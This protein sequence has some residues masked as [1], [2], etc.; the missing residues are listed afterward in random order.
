MSNREKSREIGKTPT[1]IAQFLHL[2]KKGKKFPFVIEK[3]S[4]VY[5]FD[6][7]I[8]LKCSEEFESINSKINSLLLLLKENSKALLFCKENYKKFGY[9]NPF[10]FMS[11]LNKIPN[12]PDTKRIGLLG[13]RREILKAMEEFVKR[14]K[15][16]WKEDQNFI[17]GK[18]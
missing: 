13:K 11:T 4:G 12:S 3:A 15:L 14:E 1:Y 8:F 10:S 6:K 17:G 7:K 9:K 5:K 2:A 16:E 18:K